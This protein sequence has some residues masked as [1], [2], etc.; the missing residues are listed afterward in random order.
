MKTS[1]SHDLEDPL[2]AEDED[3]RRALALLWLA[4]SAP[5]TAAPPDTL[6][7]VRARLA[8]ELAAPVRRQRW[9]AAV[10]FSGWAAAAACLAILLWRHP[11]QT[12]PDVK[13]LADHPP[14]LPAL[15][16]LPKP[17]P[18]AP[19]TDAGTVQPLTDPADLRRQL[20]DLRAALAASSQ[21]TPGTYRPV[22]R[23]LRP[24]GSP[25]PAVG[26]D[27][28]LDLIATALESDLNH[29]APSREAGREVVIESGWASWTSAL[30]ADVTFRH[31]QFPSTRWQELGLLKSDGGQFLDPAT[32]WL[33]SPD[34][35]SADYTGQLAP[36][37]LDR[38][39]F[40]STA[41]P[42]EKQSTVLPAGYLI[43]A[44]GGETIVALSG[45]PLVP[46]GASLFITAFSSDGN[47]V[48]YGVNSAAL[49]GTD[50]WNFSGLIPSGSGADFEKG[51]SL[52]V[53]DANS[54]RSTVILSTGV[55]SR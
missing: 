34:P 37:D 12:V 41:M 1:P 7:T 48:R 31:R 30:P 20:T 2:A 11:V 3:S 47:K 35:A 26:H 49:S 24:P 45:L 52:E 53:Q 9:R 23:E 51:F 43:T 33:W 42:G 46:Y 10:A 15:S 6:T 19:P 22:I 40:V 38:S 25:L 8:P 39:R 14:R 44:A 18:A 28:V 27:R 13:P 50:G 36:A 32:G 5:L 54:D 17:G 29:R 16:P 4:E 21:P 55:N